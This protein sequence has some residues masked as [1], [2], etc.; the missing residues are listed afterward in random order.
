M[1][2]ARVFLTAI[3]VFAVVGGALAFKS[4]TGI[5]TYYCSN[6]FTPGVC[7]VPVQAQFT[8]NGGSG[9]DARCSII[10]TFNND[11]DC[12]IDVVPAL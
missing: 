7:N 1:K 9:T 2:K 11:R 4:T 3:A 12:S 6:P 10:P 8:L 5:F